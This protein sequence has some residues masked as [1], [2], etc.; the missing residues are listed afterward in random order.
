MLAQPAGWPGSL[1]GSQG[2][3]RCF[4]FCYTHVYS[5]SLGSKSGNAARGKL[6]VFHFSLELRHSP[7]AGSNEFIVC[8]HKNYVIAF[9]LVQNSYFDFGVSSEEVLHVKYYSLKIVQ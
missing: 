4:V 6:T 1:L 2:A 7:K 8:V 5:I 9:G 3:T